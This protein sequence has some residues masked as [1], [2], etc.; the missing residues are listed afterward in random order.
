MLRP[1]VGLIPVSGSCSSSGC[2]G[3]PGVCSSRPSCPERHPEKHN[4]STVEKKPDESSR[5]SQRLRCVRHR[6][7][8]CC[9]PVRK[10]V[11]DAAALSFGATATRSAKSTSRQSPAA[12]PM[13]LTEGPL[14]LFCSG[15]SLHHH[16]ICPPPHRCDRNALRLLLGLLCFFTTAASSYAPDISGHIDLPQFRGQR[17]MERRAGDILELNCTAM[18]GVR[19]ILPENR[20]SGGSSSSEVRLLTIFKNFLFD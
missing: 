18:E 12:A 8:S 1:R 19:W 13:L 14:Q 3:Y 11:A 17:Y 20:S 16:S 6:R 10:P 7:S 15:L 2:S 5:V 4:A 9:S